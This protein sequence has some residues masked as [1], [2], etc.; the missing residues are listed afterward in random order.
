MKLCLFF[1]GFF[2]L[3]SCKKSATITPETTVL[4]KQYKGFPNN[5][6]DTVTSILQK[7]YGVKTV[8]SKH[9]ELYPNAYIS[10]K[11]P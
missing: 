4:I 2:L 7:I 8:I 11:S 3:I 1:L 6:V 5:E 10:V 9:Q